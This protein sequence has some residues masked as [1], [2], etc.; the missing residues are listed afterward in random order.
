LLELAVCKAGD[1]EPLASDVDDT[2]GFLPFLGLVRKLV[3]LWKLSKALKLFD[4]K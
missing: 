3:N 4:Q 1:D 2:V